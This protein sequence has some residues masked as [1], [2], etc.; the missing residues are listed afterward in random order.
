MPKVP[1]SITVIETIRDAVIRKLRKDRLLVEVQYATVDANYTSGKPQLTFDGE[2]TL[3]TPRPYLSS[4]TPA[5][6][7]RV[8]VVRGVIQG[9]IM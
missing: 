7:D 3:S 4:Y 5:A 6:G 8:M 9:K 2:S 1:D